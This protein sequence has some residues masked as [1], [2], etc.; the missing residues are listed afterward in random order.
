M[1]EM[2]WIDSSEREPP[3]D[4]PLL[5]ASRDGDFWFYALITFDSRKNCWVGIN[6]GFDTV[7][8]DSGGKRLTDIG[9]EFWKP[10]EPPKP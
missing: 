7:N 5:V 4:Q 3:H 8:R 2:T 1:T 10:I 9:W 6:G